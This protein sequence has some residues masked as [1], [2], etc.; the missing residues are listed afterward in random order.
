[1]SK[2]IYLCGPILARTTEQANEWRNKATKQLKKFTILNP[3]RRQ[4]SDKDKLGINEIVQ[5]DKEDVKNSDIIL[6]NYNCAR[7]ETTLCGTSMEIH[8]AYSLGKYIV[9]FTDL[10][11]DKWSPWMIYHSTRICK[12]F[13]EAIQYINKHF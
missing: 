2:T 6:V 9:A 5:M 10:P 1:M 4:F 8:L 13:D 3:M 12:S 7:Q 11:E